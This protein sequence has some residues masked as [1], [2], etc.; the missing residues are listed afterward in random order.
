MK[1]SHGSSWQQQVLSQCWVTSLPSQH[2]NQA[3]LSG[4]LKS[5]Y[6]QVINKHEIQVANST[7]KLNL[8]FFNEYYMQIMLKFQGEKILSL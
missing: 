1:I 3:E 8:H 2:L 7:M 6:F 5:Y 4:F